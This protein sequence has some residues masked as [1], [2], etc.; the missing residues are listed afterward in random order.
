LASRRVSKIDQVDALAPQRI[1]PDAQRLH[2]G[3][4]DLMGYF[5]PAGRLF[6]RGRDDDMIVSGGENVFPNEVEDV[7]SDHPAVAEAACIGVDDESFGQRLRAFV[8][9]LD[10]QAADEDQLSSPVKTNLARYKAPRDIVFVEEL[11]RTATG[12]VLKR[13]LQRETRSWRGSGTN[14]APASLGQVVVRNFGVRVSHARRMFEVSAQ[15]VALVSAAAPAGPARCGS[16]HCKGAHRMTQGTVKWFNAEKG[17]GFIAPE[18]G[19]ADVFVHYSE[20][21][22]AGFRSLDENQRVE[23]EVGQGAKGP[24]ATGVTAL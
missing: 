13:E 14:G 15:G 3:L 19:S 11:P 6:V 18:D 8:V 16:H 2:G 9:L 20:I 24:Q 23:F 21:S 4:E 12:K 10:G 5:D 17:F 1:D 7:L 22:G